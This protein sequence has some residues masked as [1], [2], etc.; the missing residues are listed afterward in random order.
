MD[1]LCV[2]FTNYLSIELSLLF[3]ISYQS[4]I[5]STQY[6]IHIVLEKEQEQIFQ[7]ALFP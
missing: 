2:N 7:F 5:I 6:F 1:I 3:I 4:K